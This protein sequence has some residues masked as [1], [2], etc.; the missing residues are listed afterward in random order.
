M[1]L[2]F[3]VAMPALWKTGFCFNIVRPILYFYRTNGGLLWKH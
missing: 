2:A 3:S 1:E